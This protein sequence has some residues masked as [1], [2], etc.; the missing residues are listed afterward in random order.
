MIPLDKLRSLTHAVVHANCPDGVASALIL[1]DALPH[2]CVSFVKYGTEEHKNFPAESGQI[3]CDFSPP[4]DRAQEFVSVGAVVLDHHDPKIV[5]PYGELGVFGKNELLECGAMLAYREVWVPLKKEL[6]KYKNF[7]FNTSEAYYFAKYAA[8]RDTWKRNDPDWEEANQQASELVFWKFEQLSLDQ[9]PSVPLGHRLLERQLE[10]AH[11]CLKEPFSFRSERGTRV[12]MFQGVSATSDAAEIVGDDTDLVVGF[13][14]RMDGGKLQLQF[15]TRSH[16]GFDCQA[17]AKAYGGNGHKPA[18][19][20][21]V[22]VGDMSAQPYQVFR[23]LLEQYE[24][25]K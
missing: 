17:L 21:T 12:C 11:S 3:W 10:L 2:L 18:A 5:E 25:G 19:G 14:Y 13:H 15:S 22:P 9:E 20:F 7:D 1:K 24:G 4:V 8:I 16:T 23:L 6:P